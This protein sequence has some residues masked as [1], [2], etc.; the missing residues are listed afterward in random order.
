MQGVGKRRAD[1]WALRDVGLYVRPGEVYALLGPPGSGKSTLLRLV[2]GLLQPDAGR[3][4]VDDEWID[5]LPPERRSLGMVFQHAA[6]WPHMSVFDNVA[7]GLRARA[8]RGAAVGRAV[9]AALERVGLAGLGAGRPAHLAPGQPERVALARALVIQP[10]LLLL[11]E[12]WAGLAGS[13]RERLRADLVALQRELGVTTLYAT[14]DAT[15]ALALAGRVAVLGGG[16]LLQADRPEEVYWRPRSRVAAE[17]SGPVNLLPAQVVELREAGVV[18]ALPGG[19]EL[20]VAAAAGA[21][22]IGARGLLCL[23]PEALTLEEAALAPGGIPG[24]LESMAFEGGRQ[25]YAVATRGGTLRVE[26]IASAIH[27]RALGVGDAVKV[28]VS[29]ETSVLLPDGEEEA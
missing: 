16:R 17:A 19:T 25:R 27:G 24:R 3:T 23:R 28:Q 7:F 21:W 5:P 20:P 12:P 8:L 22:R 13:L 11:D 6:L 26:T 18:V 2:A 4:Y 1:G 15:E 10:R 29:P 14:R 9:E